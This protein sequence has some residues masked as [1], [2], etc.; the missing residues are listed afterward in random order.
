MIQRSYT[1]KDLASLVHGEWI[2][3]PETKVSGLSSLEQATSQH[4]SFVNGE[5]YLEQAV[6]SQAAI[7][8][9]TRELQEKL[10]NHQN[11][12]IVENPYLAFA[13]LTHVF[14]IKKTDVGIESTAQ[15][16]PSAIISDTAYIGGALS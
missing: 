6:V 13:I 12:I 1:L 16:H 4:I 7:L 2:G 15:I 9:A 11:L 14:E 8:I 10:T 5:K 3:Q